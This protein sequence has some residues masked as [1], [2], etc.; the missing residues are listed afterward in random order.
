M[1]YL[2]FNLGQELFRNG[3]VGPVQSPFLGLTGVSSI[4][5]LFINI[6]FVLAGLI[7]LFFFIL[8]GIGMIGSAG[9]SDPQ[10]AEQAKKTITSAVIG[11]VIVFASYW[12][13]KLIG[14]LIGMPNII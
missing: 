12:I 2:T 14:Q 7:L 8:G 9:Q 10:K 5:T 6:A 4:V 1:N 13:V 3:V 11:F